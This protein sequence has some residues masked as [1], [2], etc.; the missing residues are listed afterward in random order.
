MVYGSL[1]RQMY[2]KYV[3]NQQREGPAVHEAI[4][5][6]SSII[7]N[8]SHLPLCLLMTKTQRSPVLLVEYVMK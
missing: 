4:K 1:E 8:E 5:N 6:S 2:C 7:I 3:N